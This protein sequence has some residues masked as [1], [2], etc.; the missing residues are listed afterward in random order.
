MK[1]VINKFPF[2]DLFFVIFYIN[3]NILVT[4]NNTLYMYTLYVYKKDY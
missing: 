2:M 1:K 4:L 3:L